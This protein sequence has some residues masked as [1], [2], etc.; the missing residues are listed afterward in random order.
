MN[1]SVIAASSYVHR[2]TILAKQSYGVQGVVK[3]LWFVLMLLCTF[4]VLRSLSGGNDQL[5]QMKSS[6]QRALNSATSSSTRDKSSSDP[7]DVAVTIGQQGRREHNDRCAINFFG[8]PRAFESLV[9]PSI[10]KNIIAVNPG[11]DY[12]AHY[13]HMTKEAEG[14]SGAGGKIDPTAV[15]LLRD[16]VH[17]EAKR[18]GDKVLPI[19]EFAYDKEEDFWKKYSDLIERIRTTRVKGKYLYFPWKETT[20][21]YPETTDNIVKMWHTIQSSYELMEN[22]AASKGIEYSTV[23]MF[24]LDVIYV[25]PIDIH[26]VPKPNL[27]NEIVPATITNFGNFPIS[28]RMI[29]GPR[30]A[31]KAWAT[32]RFSQLERHVNFMLKNDPGW[33]MHSERF[34]YYT[35]FPLI[36]NITSIRRHPTI[37]FF[38]ARADESIWVSDCSNEN[39]AIAAPSIIEHL[40]RGNRTFH[41]VVQDAIGRPCSKVEPIQFSTY[42][43]S[44]PCQKFAIDEIN[45]E[46]E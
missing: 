36:Q 46:K 14:R 41:N 12:Y 18:R 34:V 33:G 5:S 7:I 32:Q 9:L 26:D 25:T 42:V 11:C 30:E 2:R 13:Y 29:Y 21:K 24:R 22:I 3:R 15:L 35:L 27:T 37:C 44:L 39:P 8:L 28:D 19:V 43:L 1:L 16:A 40:L 20:Y 6:E 17:K 23:G 38:R 31:V 45:A 4:V 10:V